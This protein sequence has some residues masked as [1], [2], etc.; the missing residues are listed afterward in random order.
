MCA[1]PQTKTHRPCARASE[2]VDYL[3]QR[4]EVNT[5]QCVQQ[6]GS[7]LLRI[8]HRVPPVCHTAAGRSLPAAFR[9]SLLVT[10]FVATMSDVKMQHRMGTLQIFCAGH[11]GKTPRFSHLI[12]LE[13]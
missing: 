12:W 11:A 9:Q 1:V 3:I 5:L 10:A 7:V 6:I 2:D 13:Q 4:T 8:V